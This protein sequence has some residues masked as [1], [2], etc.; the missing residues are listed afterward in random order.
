MC[1]AKPQM[2]G[3]GKEVE[4]ESLLRKKLTIRP[5][6]LSFRCRRFGRLAAK[7]TGFGK[8]GE[9]KTTTKGFVRGRNGGISFLRTQE[10]IAEGEKDH[11]RVGPASC[12]YPRV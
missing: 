9:K 6:G 3:R 10:R 8:S 7:E 1:L 11:W 2:G 12:E 4:A 5:G